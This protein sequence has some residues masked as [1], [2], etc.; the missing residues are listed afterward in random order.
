MS[1][2]SEA[3]TQ[4]KYQT[5]KVMLY[6]YVSGEV[7]GL[8]NEN[9]LS[10]LYFETK[11]QPRNLIDMVFPAYAKRFD[12][13]DFIV[14]MKDK[15]IVVAFKKPDFKVVGYGWLHSVEGDGTEKKASIGFCFFKDLW[16]TDELRDVS[17]FTAAWW[18]YELG[19]KVFYGT[20]LKRNRLA[21]RF[22]HEMG[23]K[24]IGDLPDFFF[25]NGVLEDAHL[26][27]MTRESFQSVR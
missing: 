10:W 16:G 25:R 8:F 3:L 2:T 24:S 18:F 20:I 13:N 5:D 1:E 12:L 6:P 26:I 9:F 4:W 17:N 15:P 22:A 19:I 11:K 7:S 21:I 23:C 14:Q 27:Y